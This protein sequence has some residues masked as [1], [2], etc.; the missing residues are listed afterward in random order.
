LADALTTATTDSSFAEHAA[1]V[2]AR[3]ANDD[4]VAAAARLIR[5]LIDEDATAAD[6]TP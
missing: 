6:L 4:S 5:R 1:D 2:G 3:L